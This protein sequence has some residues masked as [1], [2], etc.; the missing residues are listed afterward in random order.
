MREVL[1]K[2]L[3]KGTKKDLDD[4]ST[5]TGITLKSCRRQVGTAAPSPTQH[6]IYSPPFHSTPLATAHLCCGSCFVPSLLSLVC[7][8]QAILHSA[9]RVT[10]QNSR[11][12]HSFLLSI[13][14]ASGS[15]SLL[16]KPHS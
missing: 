4:I 13:N 6:C 2:K 14:F 8:F 16:D 7:P 3:S 1:G 9:T 12:D 15:H 10:L 5:K 11:S